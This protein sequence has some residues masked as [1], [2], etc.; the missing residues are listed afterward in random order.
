MWPKQKNKV[1]TSLKTTL[2]NDL[3]S[4]VPKLEKRYRFLK[5]KHFGANLNHT[6]LSLSVIR[7]TF[8]SGPQ[9]IWP[10]KKKRFVQFQGR[11]QTSSHWR[12]WGRGWAERR[13]WTEGIPPPREHALLR[14]FRGNFLCNLKSLKNRVSQFTW[15]KLTW[16]K[17]FLLNPST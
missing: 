6:F 14:I 8:I 17:C 2:I 13:E 15:N 16:L 11:S 12:G 3:V 9:V 10:Q 4:K 5:L 7:F 1:S